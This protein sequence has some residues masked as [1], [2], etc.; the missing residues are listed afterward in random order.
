MFAL[1]RD[2]SASHQQSFL[3]MSFLDSWFSRLIRSILM[4]SSVLKVLT[5]S[6]PLTHPTAQAH[7]RSLLHG[8][9]PIISDTLPSSS[10]PSKGLR[11]RDG[12]DSIW[13]CWFC[14]IPSVSFHFLLHGPPSNSSSWS[15]LR[16]NT[17]DICAL[18]LLPAAPQCSPCATNS[19]L[20]VSVA[21]SAVQ[22]CCASD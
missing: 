21:T 5:V 1:P 16:T 3:A 18:M 7:R 14:Y 20:N 12:A 15:H 22:A 19:H 17:L 9:K 4:S 8:F 10:E 13:I 2:L 6:V 11:P